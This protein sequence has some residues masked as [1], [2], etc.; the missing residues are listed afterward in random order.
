MLENDKDL[1]EL[2]IQSPSVLE[3]EDRQTWFDLYTL[4]DEEQI[5]K[6]RDILTSEQDKIEEIKSEYQT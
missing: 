1:I 4:M 5:L 2:I 6:L 3:M